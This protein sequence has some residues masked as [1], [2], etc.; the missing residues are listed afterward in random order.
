MSLG[1][2]PRV[3]GMKENAGG[4]GM[5]RVGMVQSF[6]PSHSMALQVAMKCIPLQGR[7][8]LLE[9]RFQEAMTK[10]SA[11]AG[12]NICLCATQ[13]QWFHEG[14]GHQYRIC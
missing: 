13:V 14:F 5:P 2:N 11:R 1:N 8:L 7:E 3:L 4:F 12:D 6:L 10:G 9:H